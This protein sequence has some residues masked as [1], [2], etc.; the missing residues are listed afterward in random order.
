MNPRARCWCFTWNNY[1]EDWMEVLNK[2]ECN[3]IIAEPEEGTIEHTPHIQGYV[4]F[5]K[6]VYF[7][8]LKKFRSELHWEVARGTEGQNIAYCTKDGTK[9]FEKGE[10]RLSENSIKMR[11]FD[12]GRLLEDYGKMTKE[13]FYNC[14]PRISI[15]FGK[16]LQQLHSE[17]SFEKKQVTYPGDLRT[18]NFWVF[19]KPGTGKSRWAREQGLSVYNKPTNKWWDSYKGNEEIVLIEDFP[20]LIENKG[21]LGQQMKLWSDRYPFTAEVKN[22]GIV[23]QPNNFYLIV[24]SNYSI[25][26]CFNEGDVQA[27][28]RR[29]CEIP[30]LDE[31]DLFLSKKLTSRKSAMDQEN[32]SEQMLSDPLN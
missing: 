23:V 1:P 15:Q 2:L 5:G 3:Y 31:F 28:K 17:I 9:R 26:E 8:A 16:R 18:K 24:T 10:P 4:R 29:F 14:Y 21:A 25:D 30:I 13:E 22:G 27:I 12:W 6:Q 19:G 11:N 20:C 7:T 32:G